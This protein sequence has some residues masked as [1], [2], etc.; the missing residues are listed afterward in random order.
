MNLVTSETSIIIPNRTEYLHEQA[1]QGH[2]IMGVLPALYPR[3]LLWAFD[4]LP[5]EIWDPPGDILLANAHLQATICPVVKRSLEFI[6]KDPE[7]V[8][9]GYLFPHTCDSLQNLATQ[10]K[11]LI[12]VTVPVY[13]FYNPKGNF[14][15]VT[16]IFYSDILS[17]LQEALEQFHG[18]LGSDKLNAACDLGFK[19]DNRL[20]A[21]HNARKTDSL[22]LN[23]HEYFL[24]LRAGEY[25]KPEDYLEVLNQV[26]IQD[27]PRKN[28]QT[29][30]LVSGILPP[31][32]DTLCFL[33]ELKV[34]IVADDL[35]S[36]SRRFP[37]TTMDAPTN[38]ME[39]LTDRFFLLP[40]C[41]T[42]ANSLEERLHHLNKLVLESQIDGVLFNIVK[43]CEPELFDHRFLVKAV[44]DMGLPILN[45]ETELQ[46]GLSGQDKTRIEAFVEMLGGGGLA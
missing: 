38:P 4:I 19:I 23:N 44:K 27:Q 22:D 35:L 40:P 15:K 37:I 18:P 46:P 17:D 16:R 33:D 41:S 32:I 6:L 20:L 36:G 5:A 13:T 42:K 8:N 25:L 31:N 14:N 29:R 34:S 1:R 3:E 24:L 30:L 2:K 21:L 39:Y 43:F 12:G 26:K 45:L 10:V 28:D 9:S 11:D 7:L